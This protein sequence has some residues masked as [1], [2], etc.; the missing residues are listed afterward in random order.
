MES[1]ERY[2]ERR[3]KTSSC[4]NH[5]LVDVWIPNGKYIIRPVQNRNMVVGMSGNN[6]QLEENNGHLNNRHILSSF[7]HIFNPIQL[8]STFDSCI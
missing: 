5:E 2:N 3:K 7:F 4:R 8:Y 6:I 1:K